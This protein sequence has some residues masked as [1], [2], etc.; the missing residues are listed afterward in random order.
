MARFM[1][2]VP[3]RC[4]P[5]L[6]ILINGRWTASY[7]MWRYLA[8]AHVLTHSP[9]TGSANSAP[10]G[11]RRAPQMGVLPLSGQ[12]NTCFLLL[13]GSPA[14]TS[15]SSILFQQWPSLFSRNANFSSASGVQSAPRGRFVRIFFSIVSE[16]AMVGL[17]RAGW[18]G[19]SS[20]T[21]RSARRR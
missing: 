7:P 16:H 17:R 6:A 5:E 13:K 12:H 3:S 2:Q 20:D 8:L 1:A 9:S 4:H 19:R 15:S 18:Y 10:A 21:G 14:S 11:R